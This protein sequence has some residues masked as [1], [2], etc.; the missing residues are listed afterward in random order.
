MQ[1]YKPM[2]EE[3]SPTEGAPQ[4][5]QPATA[6]PLTVAS[7]PRQC[8]SNQVR[9]GIISGN[10]ESRKF[11]VHVIVK[12]IYSVFIVYIDVGCRKKSVNKVHRQW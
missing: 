4:G 7:P 10:Q 5:G 11:T 2:E 1:P 12:R 8:P 6:Q 9:L 3:G